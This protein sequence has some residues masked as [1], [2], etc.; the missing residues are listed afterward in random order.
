MIQERAIGHGETQLIRG[1]PVNHGKQ[2][3]G[4]PVFKRLPWAAVDS[5]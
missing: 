1:L 5:R 2:H 3:A 4:P